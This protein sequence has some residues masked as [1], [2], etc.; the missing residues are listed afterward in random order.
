MFVQKKTI[1]LTGSADGTGTFY[2]EVVTGK[3]VNV[4]YVK[5]GSTPLADTVDM[6]VTVEGTGQAV[7]SQDNVVASFS[8]NPRCATHD[9]L[10]VASLYAAGGEPVEDYIF[11]A[12][13]RIKVVLAQ[14]GDATKK[15]SL[16][17]TFA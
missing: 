13:D 2:S 3:I 15:G 11:V 16:I 4:S 1:A 7:L 17:V 6:A 12:N 10:G 14:A 5:P 8:L 9:V